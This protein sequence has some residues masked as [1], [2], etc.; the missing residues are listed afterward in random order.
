MKP[1]W[2]TKTFWLHILTNVV[3]FGGPALGVL[4]V[5]PQAKVATAVIGLAGIGV[6][7]LTSEPVSVP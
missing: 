5:D 7:I 3:A 6:R 2:K 1:L 4:H